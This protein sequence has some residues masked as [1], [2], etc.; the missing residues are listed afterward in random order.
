MIYRFVIDTWAWEISENLNV[1][2]ERRKAEMKFTCPLRKPRLTQSVLKWFWALTHV[3]RALDTDPDKMGSRKWASVSRNKNDPNHRPGMTERCISV[4]SED[5]RNSECQT[6]PIKFER[7][8][9]D[10]SW[11]QPREM[12]HRAIA[13][14]IKDEIAICISW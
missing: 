4:G 5:P 1:R 8:A 3:V 11:S 7:K 10:E 9:L 12:Q 2:D 13:S 6:N 14:I